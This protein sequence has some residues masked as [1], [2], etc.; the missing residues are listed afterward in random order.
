MDNQTR[1]RESAANEDPPSVGVFSSAKARM[2]AGL[3][4]H[5]NRLLQ[6]VDAGV[7]FGGR[8]AT[9]FAR[10]RFTLS[11]RFEAE[12]AMLFVASSIRSR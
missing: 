6:G 11:S 3:R 12:N 10:E 9:S 8:I 4:S 2:A 7:Y 1:E 5:R